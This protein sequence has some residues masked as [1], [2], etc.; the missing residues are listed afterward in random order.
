M[1]KLYVETKLVE[2]FYNNQIKFTAMV[3]FTVYVI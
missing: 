2:A 3:A 1:L